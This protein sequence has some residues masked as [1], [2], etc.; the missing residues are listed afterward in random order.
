MSFPIQVTILALGLVAAAGLLAHRNHH[1]VRREALLEGAR[2][3]RSRAKTKWDSKNP[4]AAIECGNCAAVL[5]RLAGAEP[6]A[7]ILQEQAA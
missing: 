5:E 1:T 4:H 3:L 6:A 2:V 7:P